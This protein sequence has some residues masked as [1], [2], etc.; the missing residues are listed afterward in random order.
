MTTIALSAVNDPVKVADSLNKVNL[1]S[2]HLMCLVND[3]LDMSKIESRKLVLH[4]ENFDLV[5]FTKEFFALVSPQAQEKQIEFRK[6]VY[7]LQEEEWYTGDTMRLK[8]ILLNLFSNALKFT[9]A[10]GRIEFGVSKISSQEMV[11]RIRFTVSDTGIGMSREEV[12]KSMNPF[13]QPTVW[14]TK[15]WRNGSWNSDYP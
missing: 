13:E 10:N 5:Q 4:N 11:D 2:H 1:S 14:C 7:G 15:I 12:E 3:V 9:P 6:T 8:Q